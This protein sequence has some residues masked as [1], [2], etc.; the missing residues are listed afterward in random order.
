MTL[1]SEGLSILYFGDLPVEKKKI[2]QYASLTRQ[3]RYHGNK[4]RHY[5]S[6]YLARTTVVNVSQ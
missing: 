2:V 5:N 6:W 1:L 4:Q 3:Y